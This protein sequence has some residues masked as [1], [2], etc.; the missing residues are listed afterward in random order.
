MAPRPS[1]RAYS[2]RRLSKSTFAGTEYQSLTG[3][4]SANTFRLATDRRSRV[5]EGIPLCRTRKSVSF[6]GWNHR[7]MAQGT[8]HPI[9]G[10]RDHRRRPGIIGRR[11]EDVDQEPAVVSKPCRREAYDGRSIDPLSRPSYIPGVNRGR[12]GSQLEDGSAWEGSMELTRRCLLRWGIML[13]GGAALI[14]TRR[15]FVVPSLTF[16]LASLAHAAPGDPR[17]VQGV[18]EWPTTLTAKPF[19]VI[20]TEDGRWYYAD[21]KSARRLEPAALT[22]GARVAVLGTEAARPH[23]ITALAFGSGDAAALALALMP[24]TNPP[25]PSSV[26]GPV[27]TAELLRPVKP[28]AAEPPKSAAKAG[29]APVAA[30]PA[31]TVQP[32]PGPPA[33]LRVGEPRKEQLT[34]VKTMTP[35]EPKPSAGAS[36]RSTDIS[37]WS[38][39]RGT[40]HAVG[41]HE[42]VVRVDDGQLVP[43]D[44]S[45]LRGVAVA[46]K[47]GSPIVVYGTRDG[48]KFQAI[49]LIQQEIR[50]LVKPVAA[51]QR[52]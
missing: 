22:V 21:I 27:T 39:L 46:L 26:S 52:H 45:G 2:G 20:R 25:T 42:V 24:H 11:V 14:P 17:L 34:P 30:A 16:A 33:H 36:A 18:L 40:V 43:A 38:E 35:S 13:G 31:T 47:P 6:S 32:E 48:E 12:S 50:P 9:P 37:R 3:Q 1:S 49:G 28:A 10:Q 4:W 23:E 44:L 19:V 8:G 51:P 5:R 41:D 29:P 15:W 7:K